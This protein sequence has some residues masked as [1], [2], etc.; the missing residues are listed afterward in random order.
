MLFAELARRLP[1]I[2]RVEVHPKRGRTHMVDNDHCD[3]KPGID[4]IEDEI[5]QL[6]RVWID[7]NP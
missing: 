5:E 1:R 7:A 6:V 4:E 3:E 2:G